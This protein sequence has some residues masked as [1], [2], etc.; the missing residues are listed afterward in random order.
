MRVAMRDLEMRGAGDII[1]IDQSGHVATIG[2][3]LYCKLLKRTIDSL[4]GK[5]PSYTLETRVEI[6]FDARLPEFYVNEVSLRM[7]IYQRLGDALSQEEVDA[8]WEEVK[9]R[10]GPPPEQAK[11]LYHLSRLRVHAAQRGYTHVKVDNVTLSYE[12]KKGNASTTNRVL[13]PKIKA[14]ED[15][16]KKICALLPD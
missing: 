13:L 10:F 11:W 1:G 8:I 16:E 12:R 7:E 15:L 14:P 6:P 3:H 4:Q 9:D 2:F 5:A